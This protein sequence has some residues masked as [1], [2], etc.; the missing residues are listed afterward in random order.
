MANLQELLTPLSPIGPSL[1]AEPRSIGEQAVFV[2]EEKV[3][4]QDPGG[5]RCAR[6]E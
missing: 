3:I 2:L 4:E 5:L 6:G 1:Q